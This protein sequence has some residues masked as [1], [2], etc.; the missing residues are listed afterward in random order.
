MRCS[1][2]RWLELHSGATRHGRTAASSDERCKNDSN[3]RQLSTRTRVC[4]FEPPLASHGRPRK[5]G[6]LGR[7]GTCA[8]FF[9]ECDSSRGAGAIA[10]TGPH[11]EKPEP[12]NKN[13][14]EAARGR[15]AFAVSCGI[16]TVIT[17]GVLLRS[18]TGHAQRRR[19]RNWAGC[20]ET[21]YKQRG[22][23]RRTT[24]ARARADGL[25]RPLREPTAA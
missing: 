13:H 20:L 2:A 15:V 23:S 3:R 4:A 24:P 14:M 1:G 7:P 17:C 19:W 21:S 16:V 8:R 6:F 10:Q 25:S 11:R 9:A 5:S 12:P 18:H 22:A